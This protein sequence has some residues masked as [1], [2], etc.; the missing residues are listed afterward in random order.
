[1]LNKNLDNQLSQ[2]Q[3]FENNKNNI[4]YRC[5]SVEEKYNNSCFSK[6]LEKE[7]LDIKHLVKNSVEKINVLFNN[8]EFKQKTS[9]KLF[10]NN[11]NK[12]NINKFDLNKQDTSF[13][14]LKK[15]DEKIN[16]I[17]KDNNIDKILVNNSKINNSFLGEG[18]EYIYN[19]NDLYEELKDLGN[20]KIKN[21]NQKNSTKN[22]SKFFQPK[23]NSNV[24]TDSKVLLNLESNKLY[25]N[26]DSNPKIKK[27]NISNTMK[28]EKRQKNGYIS[29]YLKTARHQDIVHYKDKK[30]E[31]M[32]FIQKNKNDNNNIKKKK[33]ER[34]NH[35]LKHGNTNNSVLVFDKNLE[36]TNKADK[37][38]NGKYKNNSFKKD[39]SF[40]KKSNHNNSMTVEIDL[41]LKLNN[42]SSCTNLNKNISIENKNIKK[43]KE[44]L[45]L[46]IN[47]HL[48]KGE[49]RDIY[50][51]KIINEFNSAQKDKEFSDSKNNKLHHNKLKNNLTLPSLR[52]ESPS[53]FINNQTSNKK[54]EKISTQNF[55]KMILMLNKYLINN[56]LID[57][58]S[59]PDNKKIF[60]EFALFLDK[61]IKFKK[62]IKNKDI[63]NNDVCGIKTERI[64]KKEKEKNLN[65]NI[66]VDLK[67]NTKENKKNG[68]IYKNG[69]LNEIFNKVINKYNIIIENNDK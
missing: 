14:L 61:H 57:D 47:K 4:Y 29:N 43:D 33:I 49:K 44:Q 34:N 35:A 3:K 11:I 32:K 16:S 63:D 56:N 1:M 18:E 26:K 27:L 55:L 23:K 46:S 9:K 8:E 53:K 58:Y 5:S 51:N 25:R 40:F 54:F 39:N 31:A 20:N 42:D 28:I 19:S 24:E 15:E 2:R 30:T 36:S 6:D 66:K 21:N 12:I 67:N 64:I 69:N 13:D 7:Y 37:M 45:F 65:N 17:L 10:H 41:N 48:Y 62:S 59:N 50:L 22:I 38:L 60:D 52:K 68:N